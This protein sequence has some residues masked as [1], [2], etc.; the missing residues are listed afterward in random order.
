MLSPFIELFGTICTILA[1]MVDIINLPVMIAIFI[2][3]AVFGAL[4]TVISFTTRNFL[5]KQRVK[6]TDIIRACLLCIP[7]IVFLRYVMAVTRMLA[8]L[9]MRGKKT[10][11]GSIQRV[12]INYESDTADARP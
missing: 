9:Y 3:Y 10:K 11:W 1:Y 12:K 4:L 5:S 6:F 8:P 2:I 7:E